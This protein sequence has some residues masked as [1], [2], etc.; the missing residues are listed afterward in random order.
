MMKSNQT[1]GRHSISGIILIVLTILIVLPMVLVV[2]SAF[3]NGVP[4]PGSIFSS[5]LTFDHFSVLTSD[6]VTRAF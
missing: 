2:L 1:I 4:R 6:I 5:G 3:S